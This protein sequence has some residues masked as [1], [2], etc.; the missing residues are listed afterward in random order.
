MKQSMQIN[1]LG[2][3]VMIIYLHAAF[4]TTLIQN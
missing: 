4:L 2:H 3:K 1:Y